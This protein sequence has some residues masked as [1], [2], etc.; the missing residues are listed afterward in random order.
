MDEKNMDLKVNGLC[1]CI[2]KLFM[3][4]F[5]NIIQNIKGTNYD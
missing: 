3:I 5:L 1:K 4:N 2:R